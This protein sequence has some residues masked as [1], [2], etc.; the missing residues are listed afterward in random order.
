M[1][2]TYRRPNVGYCRSFRHYHHTIRDEQ[3]R[4]RGFPNPMADDVP[5][6]DE[7]GI[8]SKVVCRLHMK[9]WSYDDISRHVKHKWKLKHHELRWVMDRRDDFNFWWRGCRCESC[10]SM[11][12]DK[13]PCLVSAW[14]RGEPYWW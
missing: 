6:G 11:T 1:S 14:E 9:G 3:R 5:Y 2:R 12:R 8:L 4:R 13:Y 10:V 7:C